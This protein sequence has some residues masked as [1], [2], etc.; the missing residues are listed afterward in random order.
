[1][2][3]LPDTS[4][5]RSSVN[6]AEAVDTMASLGTNPFIVFARHWKTKLPGAAFR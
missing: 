1:M 2:N 6:N 3:S 5:R 4:K